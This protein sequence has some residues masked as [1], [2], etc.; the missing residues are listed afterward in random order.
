MKFIATL[1]LPILFLTGCVKHIER[2]NYPAVYVDPAPKG[3]LNATYSLSLFNADLAAYT[4]S[5]RIINCS[6]A[7]DCAATIYRNRLV[8]GVM[9]EIDYVYSSYEGALYINDGKYRTTTELLQ[10]ALGTAA[11]TVGGAGTRTILS[12]VLVGVT[13]A[14]F[15]IDKNFFRQH[16][17]DAIVNSMQSG[18]DQVK[19]K[20]LMQLAQPDSVYPF[21]AA[22]SDLTAYFTAGTLPGGLQLMNQS[23]AVGAVQNRTTLYNLQVK[24]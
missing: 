7:L 22:R 6:V 13:G 16:S 4:A 23:A 2:P 1:L 10:L 18:R 17:I 24:H 15:S 12:Q 9:A 3:Q 20:I 14:S 8:Y 11:S 21:Q 5:S 19:A